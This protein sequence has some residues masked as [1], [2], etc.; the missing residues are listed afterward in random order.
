MRQKYKQP[1]PLEPL[2][3]IGPGFRGLNTELSSTIGLVDQTWA[4]AL[5]NT[6]WDEKGRIGLRKG[7]TTLTTVA[8]TTAPTVRIIHTFVRDDGT[9]SLLAATDAKLWASTDGALTWTDVSGSWAGATG[10]VKFVNFQ[11]AAYATVAGSKVWVYTGAGN[12]TEIAASPVTTGVLLSSYGR[13]WAVEDGTAT[14][15]YSALLTGSGWTGSDTG[16]IDASKVWTQGTDTIV[17]LASFGATF[18]VFG[19]RHILVY[20]DG[21]G[22]VLGIDPTQM[23]VT[24][25]VEGTGAVARDAIVTIGEGDL[26]FL[27]PLGVQ[28]LSRVIQEKNN[29]LVDLTKNVRGLVRSMISAHTGSAD[30]IQAVFSKENYFVLFLFPV[31]Q[32]VLMFD[33][34]IQMED[35]TYRVAEWRAMPYHAMNVSRLTGIVYFGLAG[36]KVAKYATYLDD[37]SVAATPIS[38]VFAT[39][40]LDGGAQSHNRLKILKEA[41]IRMFGDGTIAGTARWG[42]DFLPLNYSQTFTSTFDAA[43]AEWGIAEWGEAEFT[44]GSRMRNEAVG[45]SLEGQY[46]QL[47]LTIVSDSATQLSLQ[48]I[49]LYAKLGR[50]V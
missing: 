26:W 45:L 46:V 22:S 23:Y 16:G 33:T 47:Y 18:I 4:L 14:I 24:D 17:A 25:T 9:S 29:P 35:G 7:Y 36:G 11:D 30:G 31:S 32:R 38:M 37:S 39:P 3:L 34:R 5:Q 12:F 21:A 15:K 50:M 8:M 28:S 10:Q 2:A 1:T 48:E 44:E 41:T 6:V 13:L 40:W 27:S 19:T 42:F 43:V 20:V 49:V